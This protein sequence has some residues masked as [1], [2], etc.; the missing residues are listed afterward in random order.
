MR[1]LK[2]FISRAGLT[3]FLFLLQV[4][5]ITLSIAYLS[6]Y[7][8][9][10]YLVLE[11]IS[12]LIVISILNHEDDPTSKMPWIAVV[13][14]APPFG[15]IVFLLFNSNKPLKKHLKRYW[16][17]NEKLKINIQ[18]F[19]KLAELKKQNKLAYMQ[20]KYIENQSKTPAYSGSLTKYFASGEE[21]YENL[22]KELKKAKNFIFM[23]YFIIE[24]GVFWNSVYEVLKQKAEQGVEVR[25]M[26]DDIGSIYKLPYNFAR[27][28]SAKNLEIIKF[29]KFTPVMS[30]LHNNRDHRKITI[31]DGK[32]A[33]TGGVN[34]ADEYINKKKNKAHWSDCGLMIKGQAVQN[35]TLAFLKL[36]NL[37]SKKQENFSKYFVSCKKYEEEGLVQPFFDGPVPLYKDRIGENVYENI[38]NQATDY[39]YLTTPYLIIDHKFLNALKQAAKRGVDVRIITPHIPDKRIIFLQTRSNYKRLLEAGVKIFE[40]TPGFEHSKTIVSDDLFGVVGTFNVDYRSFVHHYENGVWLYKTKSIMNIKQDI[41]HKQEKSKVIKVGNYGFGIVKRLVSDLFSIFS[42]LM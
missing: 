7:I 31:I 42:P 41:L 33:F 10:S 6:E 24:R 21:F 26:Y 23:E 1:I 28:N 35:M 40:Y 13:L 3:T 30:A 36:Y 38:I 32:T 8:W 9:Q 20:S 2:F 25:V 17:V 27:K 14:L 34:I 18:N 5:A 29:N 11:V 15:T 16:L 22:I 19:E 4:A 39:V 12:F 37:N